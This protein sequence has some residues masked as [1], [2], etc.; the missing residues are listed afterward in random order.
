MKNLFPSLR[1][2]FGTWVYYPVLF[3]P[4]QIT[5]LVKSSHEIRESECLDDY[6]QRG[7]TSNVNKI[8]K[9]LNIEKD[10]FFNSII[11]GVFDDVPDWF[12]LD[13]S[14]IDIIEEHDRNILEE[15]MGIL[16]FSG[17]EKLFA[18]DGQHRVEAIKKRYLDDE[19]YSDQIS[20]IFVSHSDSQEGK[21]RTRKLFSDLNKTAQKVSP[22]ELAIIDE[23]DIEN[24]VARKI[25]G[26]YE[27]ISEPSISLSKTAPIKA[28]ENVFFTNLLTLVKV[29]K[30][31]SKLSFRQAK[32]IYS[33][34][35]IQEVY[36]NVSEFFD[37]LFDNIVGLEESLGNKNLTQKL[38]QE[39]HQSFMR[40][41]GL[42]ILA[43]LY[44]LGKKD[45]QLSKFKMGIK[46][47]DLS[48]KSIF[49]NNIIFINN[50]V[51]TKN[52]ILSLN[53]LAVSFGIKK[54]SDISFPDGFSKED[55]KDL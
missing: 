20:V 9:Y 10:R 49:F 55:Y 7:L 17:E 6:L 44:I 41:I 15:S 5:D 45:E 27:R 53:L 50:K 39:S 19:S 22:G 26:E 54:F 35:N 1:G 18:I 32:P 24:I 3:T 4:K 11:I 16:S 47:C 34:E 28:D 23:Q 12:S 36:S 48:L 30:V 33:T 43:N 51:A 31:I 14:S 2:V 52:K 13:L 8:V 38:R 37:I 29:S 46:T 21:K 42:E 25:Y 40:P